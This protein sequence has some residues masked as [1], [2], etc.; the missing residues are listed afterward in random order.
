MFF[1]NLS[2]EK[3]RLVNAESCEFDGSC[4]CEGNALFRNG[5]IQECI[6]AFK[7]ALRMNPSDEDARYNLALAMERLRRS[8]QMQK[9]RAQPTPKNQR[10]EAA[11]SALQPVLEGDARL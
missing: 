6:E 8:Q 1:G 2:C 7:Q 11:R 4:N 9:P 10:P 5:K 3:T